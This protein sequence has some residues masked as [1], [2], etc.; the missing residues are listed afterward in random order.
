MLSDTMWNV[1]RNEKFEG[2]VALPLRAD[3]LKLMLRE[4][5]DKEAYSA[6][7]ADVEPIV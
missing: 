3:A 4:A 6:S 7:P 1:H 5:H 2:E